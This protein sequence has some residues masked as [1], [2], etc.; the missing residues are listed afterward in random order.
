MKRR[1]VITGMGVVS[2]VG[3]GIQ[4]FWAALC[5]GVSGAGPIT[6]FDPEGYATTF[7]CE[8]KNFSSS[9]LIDPKD[10]RRMERFTQFGLVATNE[11]LLDAGISP[12]FSGVDRSRIGAI[13]GSG[14]G[15]MQIFEEQC[16]VLFEKGPRRISPFFVPMMIPDITA[17]QVSIMFGLKGPN[18][19]VVSA[20]ATA[21]HSIHVATRLI[22]SHEAEIM[23]AGGTEAPITHMGICGF[24]AMKAISTRNDEPQRAS[25]PF[26]KDRDGFVIGEG[27]GILVLEELEHARRRGARIHA[28]LIGLGASGD[29]HH[30]TAPHPDGIGAHQSI[31]AAIR[32]AGISH[33]AIDYINAHGTSTDAGDP[34]ETKAIRSV[35]GAHAD[36][37]AVSST[38]SMTG[39]CL[40][41]AGA[42]EAIAAI[43]ATKEDILPPT[44]NLEN[45][46]PACDLYYVPNKAERR[47]VNVAISNSFGFGGHNSTLI[48]SKPGF[49]RD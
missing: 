8:V 26:D 31:E 46:D 7:A 21:G 16:R 18:F 47:T 22:Q 28:E 1:V 17:G 40:G 2:P 5:A 27:A 11:A 13:I 44:I 9:P 15:G 48:L 19:S 23:V 43:M 37:L 20:C 12:D 25:R 36:Q 14:I 49:R 41:A 30:M 4:P 42:I 34:A 35:F 3:T 45:P 33:N 32:D 39:H 10:A 6:L 38:K 24:N 29:A